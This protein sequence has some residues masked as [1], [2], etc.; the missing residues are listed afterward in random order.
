MKRR[1]F[2]VRNLLLGW[3]AYWLALIIVGL[4]PAF[5]AIRR[6]ASAPPGHG[7]AN[8][9][10]SDGSLHATIVQD[11]VTTYNGAVSLTTVALLIALPP[12]VMWV[13]FLIANARTNDAGETRITQQSDTRSL[14]SGNAEFPNPSTTSKRRSR[15]G[16]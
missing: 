5:I 7:N 16:S 6:V 14:H 4:S 13:V 12:L 2:R 11:G 8:A 15:E 9:G 3:A 10:I 1:R